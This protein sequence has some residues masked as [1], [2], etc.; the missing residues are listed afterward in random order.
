MPRNHAKPYTTAVL[1]LLAGEAPADRLEALAADARRKGASTVEYEAL[2]R[3]RELGLSVYAQLGRHRRR[4]KGLSTLV[5]IARDLAAPYDL[6]SLLKVITRRARVLLGTDM[7]FIGFPDEERARVHVRASEGHTSMLTVGLVLPGDA[8]LVGDV[9]ATAAP[10]WT[11]D[12]LTDGSIRRSE[13]FDE[14]VRA[15]ALRAVMAVPLSNG[16]GTFAV[17]YAADRKVR[18][19][20]TDEISL[21]GSLGDLASAAVENARVLDRSTAIV[22]E[23]ARTADRTEAG[24]RDLRELADI[25]NRLTE[26]VLDGGDV[27]TV[28]AELAGRLGG[29]VR[30]CA[31]DGTVLADSDARPPGAPAAAPDGPAAP[32]GAAL[33]APGPGDPGLADTMRAHTAA[34][35]LKAAD[36]TWI[37][38]V[39]A[40]DEA[41]GS[42]FLRPGR[43]LTRL[44]ERLLHLATRSVAVLLLLRSGGGAADRSRVRDKLLDDLLTHSE[45]PPRQLED[46][47][48]RLGI[49]VDQPH[50]VVIARPEGGAGGRAVVWAASYARRTGGLKSMH[51][52]TAVLL[53]PG[54]DPSA[55]ARAVADEL[56]PLLG[57]PVTVSG[58]GPVTGAGSVFHGH[59][60]AQRC[61][62]AM[63]A[64]GAEGRAASVRELGFLGVLLSDDHD[65]DGFIDAT[66]GP[67]ADSDRRSSTD[68][69]RTLEAY[70]DTG[71][72]PTNAAKALHVHP[73][74]VTRRLKRVGE[75]LG[76]GWQQP[77]RS[78][79]VRT[80][81]RLARI[82]HI[83]RG[84]RTGP[85]AGPGAGPPSGQDA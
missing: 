45:H 53:L 2:E 20:T 42:L 25:Q 10:S 15:E 31:T 12:Y 66:I 27:H 85:G 38:P 64:L 34:R 5:D 61:L 77:E 30:V 16:G 52:G 8:G 24:L 4:E 41:L 71:G 68:L 44:D 7:A 23:L 72:S 51:G 83:L 36:G 82:Q 39:T 28:A 35:P 59:Q 84:R 22:S 3:A 69:T 80:A 43:P 33:D 54:T 46:K 21:M 26:L 79:E 73:N 65:V 17:L 60:E 40:G 62:D 55:A 47:A 32:E 78:F 75:L 37:A 58:A 9:L 18:H 81:L 1:E 57:A 63:T 49:D 67:V 70:F 50:V 74:T 13:A 48:R 11:P 14:V 19:F 76:P 56:S 6:N 29:A